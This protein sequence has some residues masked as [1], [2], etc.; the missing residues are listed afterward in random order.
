MPDLYDKT[1]PYFIEPEAPFARPSKG[2]SGVLWLFAIL[3]P[4]ILSYA[5]V[6]GSQSQV[7]A[8]TLGIICLL[9]I[10]ARPYVG[11]IVFVAL[12]MIRP[13]D[14]LPNLAAMRLTLAVAVVTL[15]AMW[16]GMFL[17][18]ERF[19]R[20]PVNPMLLLFGGW[21]VFA[22]FQYGQASTALTDIS[23][24]IILVFLVINLIKTPERYKFLT[25]TLIWLITYMAV[26]SVYLN[27]HG[28]ALDRN[29]IMQSQLTGI[30]ADPNDL[31]STLVVG[32]ALALVQI[33]QSKAWRKFPFILAA[34]AIFSAILYCQSRGGLL[35]TMVLFALF[36][37]SY[38]RQKWIGVI[39]GV[40]AVMGLLFFT[41]GRIND[42][43]SSGASVD[44][45][46][47]FWD[48]GLK[49][50]QWHP[51]IGDGYHGFPDQNGG[52]TAHNT[53]VLCFAENG[54][55]GFLF[56][57]G[58]VYFAYRK[59]KTTDW[60]HAPKE[61]RN[62]WLGARMMLTSYFAAVFW[63]SRTYEPVTFLFIALSV[64]QQ[65]AYDPI[66]Y[67][68]PRTPQERWMEWRRLLLLAVGMILFIWL[69]EMHER[70]YLIP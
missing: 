46:F 45:R 36:N 29:G 63:L 44:S 33:V 11:L 8:A 47:V 39:L 58:F 32:L 61:Y 6:E 24:L 38:V 67:F 4:A 15:V 12:I 31:S 59:R 56:W 13:E 53:F 52:M 55:P 19:V 54:F 41:H 70:G 3:I 48:N 25:N 18:K 43:N 64:V 42:Y 60:D 69:F 49:Q 17:K 9:V 14:Y 65:M 34:L 7:I 27:I 35:A 22:A 23:K 57:M 40:I 16:F 10:L 62:E 21:V 50:L 66:G 28:V 5:L 68:A 1:K 51:F 20:S 2:A 37:L 26:Y 30:F